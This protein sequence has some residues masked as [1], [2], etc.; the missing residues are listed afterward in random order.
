MMRPAVDRAA[1]SWLLARIDPRWLN[2]NGI[3]GT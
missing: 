3:S 2:L 1:T